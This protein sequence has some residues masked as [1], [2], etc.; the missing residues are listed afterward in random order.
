[1]NCLT[2]LLWHISCGYLFLFTEF[3]ALH[4]SRFDKR[5]EY[6][7]HSSFVHGMQQRPS[8]VNPTFM[9]LFM[10]TQS[11]VSNGFQ[12][13]DEQHEGQEIFQKSTS[14]LISLCTMLSPSIAGFWWGTRVST[15]SLDLKPGPWAFL[16]VTPRH[17]SCRDVSVVWDVYV[18]IL[19]NLRIVAGK[20]RISEKVTQFYDI[21]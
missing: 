19:G 6:P 11:S 21:K 1:M 4:S 10:T 18:P 3:L 5:I 13:N 20:S 17:V 16:D 12:R 15:R 7:L 9:F 8:K 2:Q 14:N